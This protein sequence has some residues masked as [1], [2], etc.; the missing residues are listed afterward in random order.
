[1]DGN[2]RVATTRGRG[3]GWRRALATMVLA[4][5]AL[6]AVRAATRE[7]QVEPPAAWINPVPVP[8]QVQAA[9]GTTSGGVQY[10]LGDRQR[11]LAPHDLLSYNH[12][13]KRAVTSD[14]VEDA[15]HVEVSFDPSYETLAFHSIVVHRGGRVLQRL[16]PSRIRVLQREKDLEARI[17]DGRKT[18]S[19][20]LDDVRIGD[21]VE[22]SY[23]LRGANPALRDRASGGFDLQWKVPLQSMYARLVVPEDRH[24]DIVPRNTTLQPQTLHHD[25]L[26]D[27]VWHADDVTPLDDDGNE[28]RWYDPYASVQWTE[29]PDWASVAAWAVPLYRAA[30]DQG[31]ELQA[32]VDAI[33]RSSADPG[34]RVLA[35]L[36]FVQREVRYLGIEVGVGSLV[37]RQ[38]RE[39][40]ARRFG[41]CK[42]KALL[43]AWMLRALGIAAQ[44]ALVNTQFT[45]EL[46]DLPPSAT[47][48]D[49]VVVHA[50]VAGRDYW[51]DPTRSAQKGSLATVSQADFERAL[52]IDEGTTALSPMV[53]AQ[54]ILRRREVHT[55]FD[56]SGGRGKAVTM[57]VTTVYEGESAD[58]VRDQLAS[59]SHD[60]VQS[61]YL[62]F[63][64]SYYPAVAVR[65]PFTV[66]DD[67]AANRLTVAEH[68]T[69][70]DLW[71]HSDADRRTL[72]DFYSP[73][74]DQQLHV[75][76]RTVRRGPLALQFPQRVTSVTEIRLDRDWSVGSKPARVD[77]E[78]FGY[79]I[80]K[81]A[82]GPVVTV[83]EQVDALADEAAPD[84]VASYVEHVRGARDHMGITLTLGDAA[85]ETGGGSVNLPL[86][87][88]GAIVLAGAA[89]LAC[90]A[91]RY[92]P[93]PRAAAAGAPRGL[94]GWLLLPAIGMVVTPWMNAHALWAS[95]PSL[96]AEAWSRLTVVGGADYDAWWAP[97]LL[98]ELGA[99]LLMLAFSVLLPVLFFRRRSSLPRVWLAY[100]LFAV[101]ENVFDAWAYGQLPGPSTESAGAWR[102]AAR[103]AV[104]FAIW[105]SYFLRSQRVAATFV[106]RLHPAAATPEPAPQEPPAPPAADDAPARELDATPTAA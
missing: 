83:R 64:A 33:A 62:N 95:L 42:D 19:V 5:G 25:G 6:P 40:F 1:M 75:P 52:V 45:R 76:D 80:E 58:A 41:D 11:R 12:Y 103:L 105:G 21:V 9:P 55:V 70:G 32:Q 82:K 34:E 63:Y 31:P 16:D 91:W 100:M 20:M 97:V 73:E 53:A 54:D 79:S 23:T 7:V 85:V 13:A 68:Y 10:L 37:P 84:R 74:I 66:S 2:R 94:A 99:N 61:R 43:T 67:D 24:L 27:Y 102:D 18:A 44:P 69:V 4:L 89:W 60:A 65:A 26:V 35:T 36:R 29:F 106:E 28:P 15:A 101:V 93:A 17:Y 39:V 86:A 77:D 14:G 104:N 30:P 81:H 46:D 88:L 92:D 98:V 8:L 38:P 78:A 90:R 87:L 71:K 22:F 59:D 96:S 49:H 72:L 56:A 48:F 51:L 47:L 50:S 57:D 3:A